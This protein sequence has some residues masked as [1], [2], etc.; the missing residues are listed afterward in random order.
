M[1][2]GTRYCPSCNSTDLVVESGDALLNKWLT[3]SCKRCGREL[4]T[5][6]LDK[7]TWTDPK[8]VRSGK[9]PRRQ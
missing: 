7:P 6:T 3:I 4:E 2:A 5:E 8:W 1:S 9:M